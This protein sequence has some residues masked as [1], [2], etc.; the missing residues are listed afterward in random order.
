MTGGRK[1]RAVAGSTAA[2]SSGK[3]CRH[4]CPSGPGGRS[5][6]GPYAKRERRKEGG[7]KVCGVA[8]HGSKGSSQR[9]QRQPSKPPEQPTEA[10]WKLVR[11]TRCL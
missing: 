3:G 6:C 4:T 2:V 9:S 5:R 11:Q 7:R 1:V 8:G 10:A